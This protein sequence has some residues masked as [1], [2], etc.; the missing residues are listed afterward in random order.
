MDERFT[1]ADALKIVFK[2]IP[3]S[4][5]VLAEQYVDRDRT[6]VYKWLRGSAFPSKKLFHHIIRF[7]TEHSSE[8]VSYLIRAEMNQ[9]I[10]NSPLINRFDKANDDET[11]FADY[12]ESLFSLLAAE[13][14]AEKTA[15]KAALQ[16]RPGRTLLQT[17]LPPPRLPKTCH[18]RSQG[19]R[20]RGGA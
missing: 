18:R 12:L 3:S 7:I 10:A 19:R 4:P 17:A 13:K 5:S 14:I 15:N 16:N 20:A 6:L 8:P 11:T 2:Y 1:F 9:S